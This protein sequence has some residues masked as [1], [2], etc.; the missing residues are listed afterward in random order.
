M[1]PEAIEINI[2]QSAK[3]TI[4]LPLLPTYKTVH[5]LPHTRMDGKGEQQSLWGSV[6][7]CY[8]ESR[9]VS[10][11][12]TFKEKRPGG[13]SKRNVAELGILNVFSRPMC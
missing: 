6:S 3:E 8:Q 7:T 11:P 5:P 13:G 4:G 1:Y 9:G 10:F 12:N 2:I